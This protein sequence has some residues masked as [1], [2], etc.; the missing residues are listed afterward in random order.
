MK[1]FTLLF[2]TFIFFLS[3]CVVPPVQDIRETI[4]TNIDN[5]LID[6]KSDRLSS[7]TKDVIYN[8]KAKVNNFN[9]KNEGG[10]ACNT[11]SHNI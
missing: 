4:I 2:I 10:I 9:V 6:I 5:K 3:S 8:L 7:K 1:R 11:K